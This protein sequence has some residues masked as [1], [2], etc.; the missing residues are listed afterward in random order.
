MLYS[1]VS[2]SPNIWIINQNT[3][4]I[5]YTQYSQKSIPFSYLYSEYLFK[6]ALREYL[7]N[8]IS[9]TSST[10][11]IGFK[12]NINGILKNDVFGLPEKKITLY[13][14]INNGETWNEIT[15][16][17]TDSEGKYSVTWLPSAT[18]NYLVK[19][20]WKG[21]NTF[22][23][24]E[25]TSS[26][27]VIPHKDKYIFSVISNSTVSSLSFNSTNNILSFDIEGQNDTKG[28]LKITISKDLIN[29][30]KNIEVYIDGFETNYDVVSMEDSWIL[31]INYIHSLHKFKIVL[32]SKD[33]GM[34]DSIKIP[35]FY[36]IVGIIFSIIL[37][38]KNR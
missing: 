24:S 33:G 31:N 34:I 23:K 21:N 4:Y 37:I 32:P 38:I 27:S 17:F 6:Y 9:L 7:H 20:V 26:L 3:P 15:Q 29:D 18:G 2:F 13:Y 11:Y 35:T 10:S 28:F 36:I 19:S 16:S 8:S 14:S 25:V 30:I 1:I 5:F 22:P 12:V